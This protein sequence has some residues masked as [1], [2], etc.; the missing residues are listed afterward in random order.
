MKGDRFSF[1]LL[2]GKAKAF[3]YLIFVTNQNMQKEDDSMYNFDKA[4]V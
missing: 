3:V 2:A 1:N 4:L